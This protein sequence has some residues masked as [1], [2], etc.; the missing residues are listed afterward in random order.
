MSVD[1][2]S[3]YLPIALYGASTATTTL[4]CVALVLATPSTSAATAA[5]GI[6]SVT[7]AQRANLLANYL[8]FLFLPLTMAVDMGLRLYTLA[9]KGLKAEQAGKSK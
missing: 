1:S 4:A 2:F 3:V 5:A 6:A 8:P 7:A 9:L